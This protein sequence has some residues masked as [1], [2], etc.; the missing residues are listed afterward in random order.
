MAAAPQATAE[1]LNANA[2][3]ICQLTNL[4]SFQAAEGAAKPNNAATTIVEET[5]VFVHDVIDPDAERARLKKQ[6]QEIQQAKKAVEGKLA[7]ENFVTRAKP[8]VV[9]QARDRLTQLQ[10]QLQAVETHLAELGA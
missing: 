9:A 2:D 1:V 8:E 5:Q 3:L 7:N 6:K 4:H 10:E